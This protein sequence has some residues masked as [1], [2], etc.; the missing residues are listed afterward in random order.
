MNDF[1][2]FMDAQERKRA[3]FI[4]D[5]EPFMSSREVYTV[6]VR[7]GFAGGRS[8]INN[9]LA[10]GAAAWSVLLVPA[11]PKK[12]NGSRNKAIAKREEMAAVI[13]ALDAR[14][15]ALK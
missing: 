14:K 2:R 1:T 15:A 4:I 5:G 3:H 6:A 9:R 13:A 12:G 10:R 8:V 11:N 7:K